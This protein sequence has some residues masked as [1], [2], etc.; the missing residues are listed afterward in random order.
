MAMEG[1]PK[2][3]LRRNAIRVIQRKLRR[4]FRSEIKE[5]FFMLTLE[6]RFL[7]ISRSRMKTLR[8]LSNL[9]GAALGAAPGTKACLGGRILMRVVRSLE[10]W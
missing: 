1:S 3:C 7:E 9:P 6:K 2:G 4:R 5:S 8:G 10:I